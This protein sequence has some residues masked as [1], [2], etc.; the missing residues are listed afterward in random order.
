[1]PVTG[2][3]PAG[4]YLHL[5]ET[6]IQAIRL[7]PY[8]ADLPARR[9]IRLGT[10]AGFL[11]CYFPRS[12]FRGRVSHQIQRH[13]LSIPARCAGDTTVRLMAHAVCKTVGLAYAGSNPAPATIK[14]AAQTRS[15]GPGRVR[16]GSGLD[17]RSP[18]GT[19]R[20]LTLFGQVRML[21]GAGSGL[22]ALVPLL[23]RAVEQWLG[24]RARST[25]QGCGEP[26]RWAVHWV[27]TAHRLVQCIPRARRQQPVG[28]GRDLRAVFLKR[29]DS[30]NGRAGLTRDP[31]DNARRGKDGHYA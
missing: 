22:A 31:S 29:V 6:G 13:L 2:V 23:S 28:G 14:L 9:P 19:S 15:S 12:P 8:R 24:S 4:V 11:A 17:H 5:L 30:R 1:M 21:L 18:C 10:T 16:C 26:S 3:F 7:S 25:A 20:F 27:S